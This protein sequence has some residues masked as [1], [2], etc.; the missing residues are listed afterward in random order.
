MEQDKPKT[1]EEQADEFLRQNDPF[2][3]QRSRNKCRKLEFSYLTRQQLRGIEKCEFPF[4]SLGKKQI[5][6]CE[7]QNYDIRGYVEAGDTDE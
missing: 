6:Q 5:S 4:S 3:R 7:S 2:Y 1:I